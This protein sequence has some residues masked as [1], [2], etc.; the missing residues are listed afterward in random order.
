MP[1][2]EGQYP[3]LDVTRRDGNRFDMLV[4][5]RDGNGPKARGL[6]LDASDTARHLYGRDVGHDA[7]W[8]PIAEAARIFAATAG[9]YPSLKPDYDDESL[10][11]LFFGVDS[12]G[13]EQRIV[14]WFV[15]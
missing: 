4:E 13:A 11:Y 3:Y 1:L 6:P 5:L 15:S 7:S 14:F 9:N 10:I 2:H 12:L 8:L